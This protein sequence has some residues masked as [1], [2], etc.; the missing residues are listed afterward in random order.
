MARMF[1]KF[2]DKA[3]GV[4]CTQCNERLPLEKFRGCAKCGEACCV[5]CTVGN[6]ESRVCPSC[7]TGVTI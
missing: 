7:E 4:K 1:A 6:E 5:D 2:I 3:I